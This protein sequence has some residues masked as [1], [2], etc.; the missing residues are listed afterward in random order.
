MGADRWGDGDMGYERQMTRREGKAKG[1]H[2]EFPFSP[3][4]TVLQYVGSVHDCQ[5][6]GG[7]ISGTRFDF[8]SVPPNGGLG[9]RAG[10][11]VPATPNGSGGPPRSL[12]G[13]RPAA[14]GPFG[15]VGFAGSFGKLRGAEEKGGDR[16]VGWRK[17]KGVFGLCFRCDGMCEEEN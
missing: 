13:K 7:P 6:K 8:L 14:A 9:R 16:D 5:G 15:R 3:R 1:G 4:A 11:G 10:R 12:K 17:E 2:G